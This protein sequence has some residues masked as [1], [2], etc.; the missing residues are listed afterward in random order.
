VSFKV[1]SKV[2]PYGE[3]TDM[4]LARDAIAMLETTSSFL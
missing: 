1:Q 3:V 2:L 4:S